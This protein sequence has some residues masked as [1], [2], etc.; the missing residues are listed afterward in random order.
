MMLNCCTD[1]SNTDFSADDYGD[2]ENKHSAAVNMIRYVI[3][4]NREIDTPI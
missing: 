3:L 2:E 1:S 4:N